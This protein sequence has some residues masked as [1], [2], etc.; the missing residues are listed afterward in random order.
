MKNL[1]ILLVLVFSCSIANSQTRSLNKFINH[2]KVQDN[3]L[4]ISVPGWMF[5]LAG[6][7][8]NFIDDADHEAKEILKL[9]DKINRVRVLI[10]DEHAKVES[11]DVKKLINGL[12]RDNFEELI[13]VKSEGTY[14]KLMIKEK[15]NQI[16]NITA[17]IQSDDS[18]I[19]MT[20]SGK[21]KLEDI[22]NL[23]MWDDVE[24]GDLFEI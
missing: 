3:A 13:T 12:K 19:L 7:S 14:V 24:T 9:T 4:A 1:Y 11:K 2:H 20:L 15:R 18:M 23:D 21:F 5:D 6:F 10:V 22:R 17:F 8:T 16:R